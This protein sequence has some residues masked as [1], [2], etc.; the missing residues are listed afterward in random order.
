MTRGVAG[1]RGRAKEQKARSNCSRALWQGMRCLLRKA[2]SGSHGSLACLPPQHSLRLRQVVKRLLSLLNQT[3]T[4][5]EG[6]CHPPLFLPPPPPGWLAGWLACLP[7][8]LTHHCCSSAFVLPRAGTPHRPHSLVLQ[9]VRA[10]CRAHLGKEAAGEGRRRSK[11][12]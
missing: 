1:T 11:G 8:S 6:G 4:P 12:A 9:G 7:A 3:H 10:R 2:L 5:L